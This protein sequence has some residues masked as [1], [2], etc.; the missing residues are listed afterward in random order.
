MSKQLHKISK[1]FKRS[2]NSIYAHTKT[3]PLNVFTASDFETPKMLDIFVVAFND[4]KLIETQYQFMQ[5][6]LQQNQYHYII[7]D[8]SNNLEIADKIFEF[9]QTHNITYYRL[10]QFL[11]VGPSHSHGYALNWI[12][13][14]LIKKRKNNFAFI[15]HDIFPIKPI[16]LS[17]YFMTPL[18]G[19]IRERFNCWYPW[20][21]FSFYSFD[22]MKTKT[23]NFLPC[24]YN[25]KLLD[26]GGGNYQAIYKNLDKNLWKTLPEHYINLHTDENI[27]YNSLNYKE[28]DE[29]IYNNAVEIIDDKWLHIIGGAQWG[30][31]HNKFALAMKKFGDCND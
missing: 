25:H 13:K 8:N 9:C 17:K 14:N 26:T 7:C 29:F 15:D 4:A 21:A 27:E 30:G 22:F 24:R 18:C 23:V 31:K 16:D 3:K 19:A 12:Y 28:L 10:P 6:N 1:L 11:Y 5:K 20:A 2:I